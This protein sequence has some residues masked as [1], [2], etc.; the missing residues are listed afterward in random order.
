MKTKLIW[1]ICWIISILYALT[2]LSIPFLYI[3]YAKNFE[4]KQQLSEFTREYTFSTPFRLL[5]LVTFIF[6]IYNLVI[7][8]KRKDSILNLFLLLFLN[9]LYAPVYYYHKEIK[10]FCK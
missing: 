9:V 5:G 3:F 6:W 7:W 8:N 1:I 10:S 4:V 2:I